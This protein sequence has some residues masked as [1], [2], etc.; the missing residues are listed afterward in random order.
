MTRLHAMVDVETLGGPGCCV[1][2]IAIQPFDP[3]ALK[4][5]PACR[6]FHLN[7]ADQVRAG[8]KIC[9]DTV[10]W[11]LQQD[12]SVLPPSLALEPVSWDSNKHGRYV[13]PLVMDSSEQALR[14]VEYSLYT[15][16]DKVWA[17]PPAFD[18]VV[19]HEACSAFAIEW[20]PMRF[21]SRDV[22]T[23]AEAAGIDASREF[24]GKHDPRFDCLEQVR[25]VQEAYA[26]LGMENPD[27][28]E[29]SS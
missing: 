28:D 26:K 19:L 14:Q 10:R 11:W 7:P 27:G 20:R 22:R 23:I 17:K 2:T 3:W 15:E 4:E 16:F 1:L 12:K 21:Q 18:M 5:M 8:L 6:V 24:E 13:S 29:G 9:P 25:V